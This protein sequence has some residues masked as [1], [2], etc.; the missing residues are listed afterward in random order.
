MA[1]S[2]ARVENGLMKYA[3]L[4]ALLLAACA[5]APVEAQ[6]AARCAPAGY[7][8]AQLD[9]LKA[10]DWVVADD[11]QRNALALGLADCLG[12][13]DPAVRDGIAF[14]ALAHW[15][16]ARALSQET[17]AALNSN[18]QAQLTAPDPRGFRRPFAALVLSEVARTDR[19]A[20]W[21]SGEQR[22]QLVGVSIAYLEGVRDYRGF[23]EG[24]GY[25]HG[26][27]HAG[28]L[29]LQLV[30]N[31]NVDRA[32]LERIRTAIE[33]QLAP[34]GHYYIA[35]EPERLARPILYMAQRG[36]FSEAEWTA[37][38]G[39]LAG[40]EA[41]WR[42]WHLSDAGL[43]RR[44]NLTQFAQVIYV[45]ARVSGEAAFA[46]LLPGAEAMIRALP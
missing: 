10:A 41:S 12:D 37:W 36:V 3:A 17:L 42:D 30:L 2:R 45:N 23:S 26:V 43:A 14:E 4:A 18:L 40:E 24:E 13:P 5:T 16:R 7:D 9:A 20:P 15:M 8:R 35:G 28:D 27:A 22:A 46:P 25:R 1:R 31:L 19:V 33:S 6:P 11:A 32:Q 29:M 21:L 44:H 38:F 34:T 39:G